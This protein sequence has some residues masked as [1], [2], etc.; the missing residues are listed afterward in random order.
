[1]ILVNL[2]KGIKIKVKL[3]LAPILLTGTNWIVKMIQDN[4]DSEHQ[5][6]K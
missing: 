6:V 3:I 4:R 1:M 5:K 2:K